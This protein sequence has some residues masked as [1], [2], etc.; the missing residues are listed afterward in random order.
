MEVVL[1]QNLIEIHEV[2][3]QNLD[4]R[5]AKC[6]VELENEETVVHFRYV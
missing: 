1:L 4:F 5:M 3:D 6:M 2:G